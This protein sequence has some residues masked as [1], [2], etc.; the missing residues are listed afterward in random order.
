VSTDLLTP[1][2][3]NAPAEDSVHGAPSDGTYVIVAISLTI[4]TSIE[5]A[6]SYV[7]RFRPWPLLAL[8]TVMAIKFITVAL[9]FMHLKFD[10]KILRRVFFFGALLAAAIYSAMLAI[11]HFWAPHFR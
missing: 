3:A 4:M 6:L 10:E 11:L 5:V 2:E 7:H 8:L 1:E 9:Y